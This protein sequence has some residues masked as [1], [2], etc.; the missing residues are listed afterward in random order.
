MH[1][2][3]EGLRRGLAGRLSVQFQHSELPQTL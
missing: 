3:P 2:A 1:A